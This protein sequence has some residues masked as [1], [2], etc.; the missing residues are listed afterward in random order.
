MLMNIEEKQHESLYHAPNTG[1]SLRSVFHSID[2]NHKRSGKI[3]F[4]DHLELESM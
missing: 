1:H 4:G 3:I 2:D